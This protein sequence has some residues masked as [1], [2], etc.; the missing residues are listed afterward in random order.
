LGARTSPAGDSTTAGGDDTAGDEGTAGGEARPPCF[1]Y[2]KS[3]KIEAS[4]H[5]SAFV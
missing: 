5:F 2:K 1:F 4:K 3:K